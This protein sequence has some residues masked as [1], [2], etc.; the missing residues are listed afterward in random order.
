MSEVELYDQPACKLSRWGVGNNSV[1]VT[2]LYRRLT[3]I[4][5][6][7]QTLRADFDLRRTDQAFPD[8]LTKEEELTG[9][10][11]RRF[12]SESVQPRRLDAG[13]R[14]QLGQLCDE[15]GD[16]GEVEERA[17]P[18]GE[19]HPAKRSCVFVAVDLAQARQV[20]GEA[21]ISSRLAG[22]EQRDPFVHRL[23]P[24]DYL[25]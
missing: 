11:A 4:Q 20:T 16:E 21:F 5:R 23:A 18:A 17:L 3:Y 13:Q 10:E 19:E 12:V 7:L 14:R 22:S 25:V 6:L 1:Y 2:L 8:R 15:V 24:H 9:L